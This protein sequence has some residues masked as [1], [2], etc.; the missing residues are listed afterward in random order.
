METIN[1]STIMTL[2]DF[3]ITSHLSIEVME[4]SFATLPGSQRAAFSDSLGLLHE[5]LKESKTEAAVPI[6]LA[7]RDPGAS[8]YKNPHPFLKP[9]TDLAIKY[10]SVCGSKKVSWIAI[11][12]TIDIK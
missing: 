5:W 4:G 7:R 1:S 3:F 2:G 9:H 8:L 11:Y 10:V 12:G 6:S